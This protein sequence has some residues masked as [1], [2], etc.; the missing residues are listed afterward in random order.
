MGHNFGGNMKETNQ[1]I[2]INPLI[3]YGVNNLKLN[4]DSVKDR[5]YPVRSL[6]SAPNSNFSVGAVFNIEGLGRSLYIRAANFEVTKKAGKRTNL[7][8]GM[9][10]EN[11][12]L[13]I[14][15][16]IFGPGSQAIKA[17]VIGAPKDSNDKVPC[18]PCGNCRQTI[19]HF[20]AGGDKGDIAI[21]NVFADKSVH[22][23]YTAK[24]LLKEGFDFGDRKNIH[25]ANSNII[26]TDQEIND[27]L[28]RK[29]DLK[30]REIFNWARQLNGDRIA[31]EENDRI[32]LK[33]SN[34]A[35]VAGVNFENAAFPVST[36]AGQSAVAISRM[37]YPETPLHNNI[38]INEVHQF[39][40]DEKTNKV[41][42]DI[43]GN[44]LDAIVAHASKKLKIFNYDMAGK[45]IENKSLQNYVGYKVNSRQI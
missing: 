8:A 17:W 37:L 41:V 14:S 7:K 9:C 25:N 5:L 35:Y 31:T 19:K 32:I 26:I 33:L 40:V 16:V 29:G 34:G 36:G 10:A 24:E 45:A 2:Q 15:S 4:E 42:M 43:N 20:V 11:T 1:A 39:C 13:A 22:D 3:F 27:R 21:V 28:T 6:S 38:E 18:T 30:S 23:N 44:D 12:V